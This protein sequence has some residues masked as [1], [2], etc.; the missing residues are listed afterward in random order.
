LEV[1]ADFN[2]KIIHVPGKMNQLAD[3][4]SHM[5]S[6]EPKGVVQAASEYV[7]T[8]EENAP[9]ELILNMVSAPLY[10]GKSIFL[11]AASTKCKA[12]Q[13]FPNVRR[14]VLK[15]SSASDQ[16]EGESTPEIPETFEMPAETAP[17][18]SELAV[19]DRAT[20]PPANPE[21]SFKPVCSPLLEHG[22]SDL[23]TQDD[24][25]VAEE[26][27]FEDLIGFTDVLD[28]GDPTS[29]IHNHI[30]GQY[31][32]DPFFDLIM[33]NPQDYKNFEV[34]NGLVF[35]K[36]K[37]RQ[38]LCIP[39]IMVGPRRL[40]EVLISHAHSILAHLGPK[41]TI[42]YLH[43]NVWWKGLNSDILAFCRSCNI[44]KTLK[45]L[46]HTPY[47]PL[48]SLEVPTQP[49][50]TIRIDFVGPLPKSKTVNGSF[51]MIIVIICHLTSLVQLIPTK[52][53]YCAEDIAKVIF[54]RVYKH[55]RM[56]KNIVSDC[57]TLSTST[58]W[59][60]L[61]KLAGTEL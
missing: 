1:L 2:F 53:T 3:A 15:V 61:H 23:H 21:G 34:S 26:L 58:F 4:L 12:W 19:H 60:R 29:D 14:V 46:N 22:T 56:P 11:G 35:L 24:S 54:N 7:S 5:Y 17:T 37:E 32:D 49:C 59:R 38:L 44:C 18:I 40:R 10:T 8:E 57:N 36:D 20:E 31:S 9:P 55:H 13:A 39:D 27:L 50:E 51:D 25:T 33:K 47:G 6:D 45:P 28:S 43:D 16:L 42:N 30:L 41:K 52:Q 48:N